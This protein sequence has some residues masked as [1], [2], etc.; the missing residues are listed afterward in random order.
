M[1][2]IPDPIPPF[3]PP[4]PIGYT[5]VKEPWT[6]KV[7]NQL[8]LL[9]HSGKNL[10]SKGYFLEVV[11]WFVGAWLLY[12]VYSMLSLLL[13]ALAWAGFL[14]AFHALV[15]YLA[16]FTCERPFF[17]PQTARH[18]GKGARAAVWLQNCYV[19]QLLTIGISQAFL[20]VGGRRR[21]QHFVIVTSPRTGST[22]LVN[23]LNAHPQAQ[24]NGEILNPAY[25]VYGDVCAAKPAR[26]TTHVQSLYSAPWSSGC[27]AVG[28]KVF[29]EHFH[30]CF[31]EPGAF[32]RML[33]ASAGPK[34]KVILLY[35]KSLLETYLSLEK[36]FATDVWFSTSEDGTEAGAGR[37][38]RDGPGDRGLAPADGCPAF[39]LKF[40]RAHFELFCKTE[41][42]GWAAAVRALE[43]AGHPHDQ[44]MVVEYRELARS[45]AASAEVGAGGGEG[46]SCAVADVVRF[47]GLQSQA[48]HPRM[49]SVKQN[50]A[51]LHESIVNY[52]AAGIDGILR[53][54]SSYELSVP[55]T[56]E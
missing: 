41:R 35:R 32:L 6:E 5:K 29:I 36:A 20:R 31:L 4:P 18:L 34:P 12:Q 13:E 42:A 26:Q 55:A 33:G 1:S 54:A 37:N 16:P 40:D 52:E 3:C 14:V 39:K 7:F 17:L 24:C 27:V 21:R 50:Q 45:A 2:P 47:L 48:L 15:T 28:A 53:D 56:F 30:R 38:S 49:V 8:R 11:T 46:A 19:F 25:M 51:A 10:K 9:R 22:L 23:L 43:D 44:C